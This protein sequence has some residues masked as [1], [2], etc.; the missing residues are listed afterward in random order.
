MNAKEE[1][2]A[3]FEEQLKFCNHPECD[4]QRARL[5]E[6]AAAAVAGA[7]APLVEALENYAII[8]NEDGN[9]QC[10]ICGEIEDHKPDCLLADTAALAE[11]TP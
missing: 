4:M 8:E 7:R 9:G 11:E 3:A 2:R 10:L 1:A 6:K 5:R